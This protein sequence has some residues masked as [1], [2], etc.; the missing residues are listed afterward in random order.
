MEA[1]DPYP[2]MGEKVGFTRTISESDVY[3]FAGLTRDYHDMHMNEEYAKQTSYGRR[4]VHGAYLVG[5]M[6]GAS[7]LMGEKISVPNV[8]YGYDKIRF[9]RPVFIGDTIRIEAEV[10]EL[11]REKNEVV[12]KES[13]LN[14][15]G[16]LA[17]VA[18]HILKLV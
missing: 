15:S 6:S 3:L 16:E 11:R 7:A 17:A 18:Y 9:R 13:C 14:Q 2:A 10:S 4:L 5:L 12:L 8:S 1:H